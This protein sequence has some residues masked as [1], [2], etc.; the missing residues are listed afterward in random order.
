[1]GRRRG[2]W[3]ETGC[4]AALM[5]ARE[6]GLGVVRVS[7]ESTGTRHDCRARDAASPAEC[8]GRKPRANLAAHVSAGL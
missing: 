2:D 6:G 3:R 1:M 5:R 7:A 8:V 4:Q